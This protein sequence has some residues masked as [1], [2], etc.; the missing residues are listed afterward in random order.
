[1][2]KIIWASYWYNP[3]AWEFWSKSRVSEEDLFLARQPLQKHRVRVRVFPKRGI[4]DIGVFEGRLISM[5][6]SMDANSAVR[7]TC[8]LKFATK[9]DEDLNF[10]DIALN[11][12][13]ML[14]EGV[15]NLSSGFYKWY[16][17]GHYVINNYS[18]S[19]SNTERI[20]SLSLSDFMS[21]I[22]GDRD[23]VIQGY[24]PSI[25][26]ID[27]NQFY[28]DKMNE[29]ESIIATTDSDSERNTYI[30]K[31]NDLIN[32]YSNKIPIEDAMEDITHQFYQQTSYGWAWEFMP[33]T[34]DAGVSGALEGEWYDPLQDNYTVPYD[35]KFSTGVTLFE[36]LDK[37]THLYP[38]YEL[39]FDECHCLR[40]R[41]K[42]STEVITNR[43]ETFMLV[44][45]FEG[46]VISEEVNRDMTKMFNSCTVYGKDGIYKGSAELFWHTV[47]TPDK[48]GIVHKEFAGEE[49]SML[50]SDQECQ[51]WAEYLLEQNTVLNDTL[52]VTLV[53]CPFINDVNY[54]VDY[55]SHFMLRDWQWDD[56]NINGIVPTQVT[57]VITNVSTSFEN[58]TTT[59][60][61]S[62]V[63]LGSVTKQ[64]L[65][66]D[67]PVITSY[68]LDNLTTLT[69]EV[70]EVQ[71]AERYILYCDGKQIATSTSNVITYTFT[72][73]HEGQHAIYIIAD[74]E[75]FYN[76]EPSEMLVV[77]IDLHGLKDSNDEYIRDSEGEVIK[78]SESNS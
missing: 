52:T 78:D 35:I 66:L 11:Q 15:M 9:L 69:I 29:Y 53:N 30:Q 31:V 46:L 75:R 25:E 56:D 40:N 23:G 17:K 2:S 20:V 73:E 22:N 24:N 33:V 8:T 38:A 68:S 6:F 54:K 63:D 32:Q 19:I 42:P 27:Y 10:R 71:Y 5:D 64:H 65:T 49:Y 55:P 14:E 61:L 45:D 36:V 72:E 74:N 7:R 1:M 34:N 18:L 76:S 12:E 48:I 51:D 28:R 4:Q 62:R 26:V 16:N 43:M 57:C 3:D 44:E 60:T 39:F 37:L 70:S 58:N 59:L 13:V 67:T 21:V 77:N 50:T 47:Y 41:R